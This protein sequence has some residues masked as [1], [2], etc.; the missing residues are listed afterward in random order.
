MYCK[1]EI[2][3]QGMTRIA[4]NLTPFGDAIDET[5]SKAK[6]GSFYRDKISRKEV[7]RDVK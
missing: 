5:R 7:V 3:P 4:P 2:I 6:G 1:V